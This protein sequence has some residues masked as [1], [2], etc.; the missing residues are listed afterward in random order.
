LAAR[1]MR[2]SGCEAIDHM[3]VAEGRYGGRVNMASKIWDNVGPQIICEEAG[4]I[5]TTHD[6]SPLD[7]INPLTKLDQNYTVCA[8]PPT[9]HKQ[10]QAIV[11]G[12]S[13]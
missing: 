12:R 3:Y 2:N 10:L 6:G 8:A 13:K 5:W 11:H 9:L 4:A 7:Y 1:N